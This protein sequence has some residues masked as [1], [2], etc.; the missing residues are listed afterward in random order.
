VRERDRKSEIGRERGTVY[1][2]VACAYLLVCVHVFA[3]VQIY[4]HTFIHTY[5][6]DVSRTITANVSR[7]ERMHC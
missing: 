2:C 5:I 4:I 7:L 1:V 6:P 3:H